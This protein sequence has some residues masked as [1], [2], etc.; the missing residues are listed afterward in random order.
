MYLKKHHVLL[1][2]LALLSAGSTTA[3]Q[4]K[5][6]R[7]IEWYLKALP[8][9]CFDL[10]D[11]R[12]AMASA[13]I[14]TLDNRNGYTG[15]KRNELEPDFFQA[16]LFKTK[17]GG[18][19][20]AVSTRECE[21]FAC[22]NP[23]SYIFH[24]TSNGW[25]E[26]EAG[27]FSGISKRMFYEDTSLYRLLDEYAGYFKLNYILPRKGKLVKVELEVCEYIA[28]DHPEVSETDYEKLVK[29][30]Q[31]VYLLWNAAAQRFERI[32]KPGAGGQKTEGRS[33]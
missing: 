21:A 10:C 25:E 24:Y 5:Q 8:D 1:V 11:W 3:Q 23:R 16:A 6:R 2:S 22:F 30:K 13:T 26:A 20:V 18:D 9:S 28:I 14:K 12:G 4:A 7:N 32:M 27:F 19:Y 17:N 15:F 33:G 31:P 29:Y